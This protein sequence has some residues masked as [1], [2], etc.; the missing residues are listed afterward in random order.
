MELQYIQFFIFLLLN[1]KVGNNTIMFYKLPEVDEYENDKVNP[2]A[3]L[4]KKPMKKDNRR[5]I[6]GL[7]NGL[8]CL[9]KMSHGKTWKSS[10]NNFLIF[11]LMALILDDNNHFKEEVILQYKD[12]NVNS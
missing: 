10:T 12:Q 3:V 11:T 9:K 5:I 4:D 1:K 8:I 7:V 6:I 2:M